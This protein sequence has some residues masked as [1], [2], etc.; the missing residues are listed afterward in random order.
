MWFKKVR[1]A[2]RRA[3]HDPGRLRDHRGESLMGVF[4]ALLTIAVTR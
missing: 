3:V 1:P 2:A 4:L